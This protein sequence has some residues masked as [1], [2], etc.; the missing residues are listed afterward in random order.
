M[1]YLVVVAAKVIFVAVARAAAAA[2]AAAAEAAVSFS[3]H[4]ISRLLPSA[5]ICRSVLQPKP[6]P[7]MPLQTRWPGPA[8]P[9]RDSKR[10]RHGSGPIGSRRL[11]VLE[12]WLSGLL[13]LRYIWGMQFKFYSG[14]FVLC[15]TCLRGGG[16]VSTCIGLLTLHRHHMQTGGHSN[17]TGMTQESMG[18]KPTIHTEPKGQ[19]L[20][21][22]VRTES[23]LSRNTFG[24]LGFSPPLVSAQ[25]MIPHPRN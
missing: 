4:L 17:G 16:T 6:E 10:S 24:W 13:T 12:L 2:A 23:G 25:E 1:W 20:E 22:C 11:R 19:A 7:W 8:E 9:L 21:K 14:M 15:S 5:K 3:P 18:R